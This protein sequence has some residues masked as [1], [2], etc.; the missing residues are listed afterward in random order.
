MICGNYKGY[1]IINVGI[2]N[3]NVNYVNTEIKAN[4]SLNISLLNRNNYKIE[5]IIDN[6]LFQNYTSYGIEN[7]DSLIMEYFIRIDYLYE[8]ENIEYQ[9]RNNGIG[10]LNFNTLNKSNYIIYS[11]SSSSL[12]DYS[13][14]DGD[15]GRFYTIIGSNVKLYKI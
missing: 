12:F 2:S 9:I 7:K 5:L 1:G 6:P 14:N 13:V 10:N 3:D 4:I 11:I 8:N 15:V